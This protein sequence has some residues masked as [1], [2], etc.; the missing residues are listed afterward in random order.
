MNIRKTTITITVINT[1]GC[2]GTGRVIDAYGRKN[3]SDIILMQEISTNE[4]DRKG[5]EFNAR[6]H[7]YRVYFATGQE[8]RKGTENAKGGLLRWQEKICRRKCSM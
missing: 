2:P 1:Q 8:K 5:I 6:E 7:G 3:A 4:G